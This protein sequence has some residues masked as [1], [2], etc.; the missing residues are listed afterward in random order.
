MTYVGITKKR[1]K[2]EQKNVRFP[3]GKR[4]T[5]VP[6]SK[7]AGTIKKMKPE[8][9]TKYYAV[10]WRPAAKTAIRQGR[11][12]LNPFL[13]L[14]KIRPTLIP[15]SSCSKT[16]VRLLKRGKKLWMTKNKRFRGGNSND[17]CHKTP[18]MAENK[19][20]RRGDTGVL[21]QL[22]LRI[23]RYFFLCAV[24]CCIA[25]TKTPIHSP[26]VSN[27]ALS[28]NDD[29]RSRRFFFFLLYS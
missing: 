16:W 27:D 15:N 19:R 29:S 24:N 28:E 23:T 11:G 1:R 10:S 9:K 18:K 3:T 25:R 20:F 17:T 22:H 5:P 14:R 26:W 4:K 7:Y 21:I 12:H 6:T 2:I 13:L 8:R